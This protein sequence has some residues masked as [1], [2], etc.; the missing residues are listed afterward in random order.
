[1]IE[2]VFVLL[3]QL[4]GFVEV[5]RQANLSRA[6]ESLY[7]TQPALSFRLQS[8]EAEL[9]QTLFVRSR[10]GMELTDAGRAFLPYAQRALDTL[11]DGAHLVAQMG[12][13]AVGELRIGAAPAISTYVLPLLL[14]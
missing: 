10:T 1:M 3:N 11:A 9:G 14:V 6:A 13:G 7:V 12:Q 2:E 5:A 4:E 8:L